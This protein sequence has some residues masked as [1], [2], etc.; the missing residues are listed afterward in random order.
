MF[1]RS[2]IFA[3]VAA[4]LVSVAAV[5]GQS[6]KTGPLTWSISDGTLTISGGGAMPN[7]SITAPWY[8][9]KNSITKAVI[10]D[11]VTSI[12]SYAFY[13]CSGLTS[14]TIPSSV[15]S[16]GS[17]AFYD[18]SGLTSVTIPSSVTSIGSSA[19]SYCSGLTSVTIPSS[20]TS[21]GS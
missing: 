19:F 4:M 13:D 12:G 3:V 18:C 9:Y 1:D 7:Y 10:G 11:S 16:I 14:V 5:F 17:Y 20:V 6:G 21:I 2:K 8:F 15:T